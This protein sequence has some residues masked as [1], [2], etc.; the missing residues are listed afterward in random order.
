MTETTHHRF[1]ETA[2]PEDTS[3]STIS[4]GGHDAGNFGSGAES[5]TD[6]RDT[7]RTSFDRPADST[8]GAAPEP[9]KFR[10]RRDGMIAG[11]CGGAGDL[12]GIDATVV[13]V[14]LVAATVLG[15][16]SGILLYAICWAVVPQE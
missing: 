16:G 10:R 4:G 9:R 6:A 8:P 3:A 7:G 14:G 12:L 11:V 2:Q 15:F 5:G 1:N 13:R